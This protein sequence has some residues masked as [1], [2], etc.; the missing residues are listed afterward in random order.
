MH[1]LLYLLICLAMCA[2]GQN[3]VAKTAAVANSKH[4]LGIVPLRGGA[5]A[6]DQRY[7]LLVCKKLPAYSAAEFADQ[8]VC[9]SALL[10]KDGQEVDLVGNKLDGV[11][12]DVTHLESY[13]APAAREFGQSPLSEKRGSSVASHAMIGGLSVL[14]GVLYQKHLL[15]A[16]K[17]STPP[18]S[19]LDSLI[20]VTSVVAT[21]GLIVFGALIVVGAVNRGIKIAKRNERR[22]RSGDDAGREYPKRTARGRISKAKLI[23]TDLI[24]HQHWRDISL[25]DFRAVTNLEYESNLRAILV[26][27]ARFYKLKVNTDALAL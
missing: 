18:A 13:L 3:P 25:V 15:S 14:L 10:T 17:V 2:C 7:R 22:E 24:A 21:A 11:S 5:T 23:P 8:N 27:M 20:H 12:K 16:D 9:R 26:A 1:K 19:G 6:E 4:V